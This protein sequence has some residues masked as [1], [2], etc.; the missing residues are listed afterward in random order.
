MCLATMAVEIVPTF[1][2]PKATS[3]FGFWRMACS[4]AHSQIM[5]RD[6]KAKEYFG[7]DDQ[8]LLVLRTVFCFTKRRH[9]HNI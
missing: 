1:Q 6:R 3:R 2:R 5:E 8:D 7:D 9:D 4:P